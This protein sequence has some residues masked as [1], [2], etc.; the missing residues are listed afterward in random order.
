MDVRIV[1]FIGQLIETTTRV[2]NSQLFPLQIYTKIC[3]IQFSKT[4]TR[5]S[6]TY[7]MPE[8]VFGW[9]AVTALQTVAVGTKSMDISANSLFT[10]SEIKTASQIKHEPIN[11]KKSIDKFEKPK[12]CMNKDFIWLMNL[13]SKT[14]VTFQGKSVRD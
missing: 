12:D 4:T 3:N 10:N 6:I 2:S 5:N 7:K 1:V 14:H 9:L 13:R 11:K 8:S